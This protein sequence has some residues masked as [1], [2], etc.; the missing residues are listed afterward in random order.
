MQPNVQT[1]AYLADTAQS[2]NYKKMLEVAVR[3][4]T[5][6]ECDIVLSALEQIRRKK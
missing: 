2:V 4:L 3:A 5:E 6:E 1:T